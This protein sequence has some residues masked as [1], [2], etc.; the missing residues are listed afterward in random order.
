RRRQPGARGRGDRLAPVTGTPD[1]AL[2]D[3][4]RAG[5]LA[6]PGS[7]VDDHVHGAL[8]EQGAVLDSTSVTAL[9]AAIGA[10]LTGAGPL[11]PLLDDPRVTDVLVNGPAEVWVD[12]GG[13]L[14][15]VA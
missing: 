3:R 2:V 14:Q 5:L 11:Q 1:R 12:R 13:G 6:A 10:E 7:S 8:R 4:V 15:R 9:A